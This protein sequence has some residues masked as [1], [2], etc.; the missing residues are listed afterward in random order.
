MTPEDLAQ[1]VLDSLAAAISSGALSCD[2]AVVPSETK[3]ERPKSREHGDWATNIAM[4]VAKSAG[5]PPRVIADAV[6]AELRTRDG[7]ASVDVAGPGFINISLAA[8]AAGELA[9]GIVSAGAG[10][11]LSS[12]FAGESINKIGRAHV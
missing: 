5:L 8:G 10:Y 11:G 6:A 2:R 4:Q 9:R 1:H 12:G 3:I 7:I